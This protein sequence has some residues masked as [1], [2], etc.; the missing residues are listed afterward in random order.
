MPTPPFVLAL[1]ERV[2]HDQLWLPGV[3]AVVLREHDART[4]VLLVRRADTGEWTPVTG[5][6]DPAE[7]PAV[8][9]VREV[10]EE[11]DVVATAQRLAHVGVVGPVVYDNGDR[12][13]YLDLT[14]RCRWESG[15]PA[16]A[17]GE[18]TDAAWYDLD[19][20]PPMSASM[21]ARLD[22]ALPERG[23]ATFTA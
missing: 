19:D 3:T 1:R 4:Q 18:N 8:A 15:V 17:D 9:A 21:R 2:G 14:F 7:E 20:L 10:L 11:A 23:E 13:V 12:S 22:A 16:P 5:I 6:V